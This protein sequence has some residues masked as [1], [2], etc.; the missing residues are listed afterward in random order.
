MK[1]IL[2]LEKNRKFLLSDRLCAS[3]IRSLDPPE[4]HVS[5]VD[6]EH[7]ALRVVLHDRGII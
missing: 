4:R 6:G 7:A 1:D 2:Y 5:E 3:F